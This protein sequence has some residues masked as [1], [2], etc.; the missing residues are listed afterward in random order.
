MDSKVSFPPNE[1][2]YSLVDELENKAD[3]SIS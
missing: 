3:M 2:R 1:V